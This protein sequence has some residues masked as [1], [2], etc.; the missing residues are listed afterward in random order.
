MLPKCDL[1]AVHEFSHGAMENWGLITYVFLQLTGLIP[2]DHSIVVRWAI[3]WHEI[4]D[5]SCL[6]SSSRTC[7]SMVWK[8][9]HYGMVEFSLVVNFLASSNSG[10]MRVLRHG[11]DGS[12]LI[13]FSLNGIFGANSLQTLCRLLWQWT[14]WMEATP[15]KSTSTTLWKS[16]KFL[17]QSVTWKEAVVFECCPTI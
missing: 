14:R 12:L 2:E 3:E 9:C 13:I 5:S 15:S 16:I 4:Q 6:R 8:S 7:P 1:V 17:M 11:W 10:W